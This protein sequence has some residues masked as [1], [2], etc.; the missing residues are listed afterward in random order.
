MAFTTGAMSRKKHGEG[1]Y[2]LMIR[3]VNE[4]EFEDF[5]NPWT[6][7]HL[8]TS[9]TN[10][11]FSWLRRQGLLASEITCSKCGTQ[12]T[13]KQRERSSDGYTFRCRGSKHEYGMRKYSF[14][15]GSAYNIRD[16]MIFIKQYLEGNSLHQCALATGMDYSSGLG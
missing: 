8:F 2:D 5:V 7:H 10:E 13:L 11:V 1:S 4:I 9:D 14:F 3:N 6:F 12:A 16:L 15:E